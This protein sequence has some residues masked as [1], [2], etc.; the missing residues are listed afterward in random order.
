MNLDFSSSSLPFSKVLD[1]KVASSE[2]VAVVIPALNEEATIGNIVST[3]RRDLMENFPIV[4]EL[5]VMDGESDDSTADIAKSFGA[6]VF[7]VAHGVGGTKPRGKGT[8]LWRSLFHVKST[9]VIYVDADIENFTSH[10]V[11]ALLVPLLE[12]SNV[13]YVKAFYDRPIMVNGVLHAAGGGRVTEILVR[14]MFSRFFPEATE[15]I[16][17]LAG[18]YGFRVDLARQLLFYTG[19]GVETSLTLD[20]LEKFGS[21][22]VVQVDLG[23]RIH[24]NRPLS[25][26]SLMASV[27]LQTI[28]D[29]ACDRGI[30]DDTKRG[31]DQHVAVTAYGCSVKIIDQIRLPLVSEVLRESL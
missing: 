8:A 5:I 24:R 3:I 14:P 29:I 31:K 19:Y 22:R 25:E 30:L 9:L 1:L 11:T 7:S 4:D 17:P 23:V 28:T 13:G 20:F 2:R 27:I 12:N 10:F 6:T 16:Q 26:L 18:E 21:D 15:F